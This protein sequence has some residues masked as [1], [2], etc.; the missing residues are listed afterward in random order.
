MTVRLSV[1]VNK[2]ATLRNSRGG[3]S[4]RVVDAVDVCLAAGVQGITVHPR[5][6]RRHITLDDVREIAASLKN[7]QPHVEFNIE[8]DP[9]RELLALVHEVRPDQ[10]TLA[11]T[12]LSRPT[13]CCRQAGRR[14]PMPR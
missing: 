5:A 1:N 11:P 6:D 8:G 3:K 4:P 2:I 7:R 13:R 10:C 14:H 9:R 12:W